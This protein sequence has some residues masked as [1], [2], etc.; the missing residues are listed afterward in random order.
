MYC[1]EYFLNC[2]DQGCTNHMTS[3]DVDP[4]ILFYEEQLQLLTDVHLS[5][6]MKYQFLPPILYIHDFN[7]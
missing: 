7:E 1:N 4:N 5:K 6:K 3:L 2:W